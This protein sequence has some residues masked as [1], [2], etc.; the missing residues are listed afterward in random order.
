MAT[1]QVQTFREFLELVENHELRSAHRVFPLLS[2]YREVL[3]QADRRGGTLPIDV[4]AHMT[5]TGMREGAFAMIVGWLTEHGMCLTGEGDALYIHPIGRRLF[6]GFEA[7]GVHPERWV[8]L[9]ETFG[10]TEVLLD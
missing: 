10:C 2:F 7:F 6:D 4:L 1:D 8:E 5:G 9:A 3:D